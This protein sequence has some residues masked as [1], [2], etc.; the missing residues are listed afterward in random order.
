MKRFVK[1]WMLGL[2]I[3]GFMVFG[4]GEK[5][6][7]A[8]TVA[9]FGNGG[10]LDIDYQVQARAAQSDIGPNGASGHSGVDN[11]LQ[12]N[13]ISFLG[14]FDQTYGYAFQVEYPGG[15]WIDSTHVLSR[16]D[17]PSYK[18][19][20]LDYYLTANYAD[21]FNIRVGRTKHVLTREVSEG[22]FEPLSADRSYFI[23]GPFGNNGEKTT[24]DDGIVFWGNFFND[25]FQY[26]LA[27]MAGNKFGDQHP[28]DI[29]YRYTGR[30]HVSL[31]DPENGIGYKGTYLGKKKVL[32]FGAG[33][34]MEPNAVFSS[35]AGGIGS[36]AE[37]Y[38]AYTYD[39]F[40]EYPTEMG[41][42]TLSGAHLKQ[43]FNAAG[44]RDV[45]G[46]TGANGEKNGNYVKAAYMLGKYQV[47][48]RK[49]KWAFANLDGIADQHV[50]WNVVGINYFI[51][52][53]DLRL[54]L[55]LEKV[56]FNTLPAKDF[57]TTLLQLQAR[58]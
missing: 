16:E 53:Q 9:E 35:F 20:A 31:L 3:C 17:A 33:Y 47:Y 29:G 6:V 39:G 32:T 8:Y 13:R 24:R 25:V 7:M 1:G 56:A 58:F 28:D 18:L 26:R 54:T 10:F 23:L 38:K 46:A 21:S 22:C 2:L 11:Y 50:D 4:L 37:N 40:F 12:R 48:G 43:D 51:K 57:K 45:P 27:A 5:N 41:T 52:G 55:E 30:I 19:S 49:E 14:M 42:F 44:T 15:Q 36:G 34:E